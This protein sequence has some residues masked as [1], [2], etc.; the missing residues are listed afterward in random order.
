MRVWPGEPYPLGATFDGAGT[1]FSLFSEVAEKVEL[2]L[3]AE[4]GEETRV[5]LPERTALVWHGYLPQVQPGQLYGY[6][7]HGRWAPAE[8]LRSD[9][10]KLLLDPYSKAV[11]GEVRWD[12]AMYDHAVDDADG[13]PDGADSAPFFS[14]P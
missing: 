3:F 8:G 7:V 5:E 11:A 13:P 2:C 1:N 6:R 14:K 12:R 9:P 10:A 4:G